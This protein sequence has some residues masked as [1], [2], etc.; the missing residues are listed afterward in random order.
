M[1]WNSFLPL[2]MY[3]LLFS[4]IFELITML[5]LIINS[6]FLLKTQAQHRRKCEAINKLVFS[7]TRQWQN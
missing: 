3:K 7:S 1:K 4:V 2:I 6:N 5:I